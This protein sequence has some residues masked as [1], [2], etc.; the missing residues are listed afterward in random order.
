MRSR[1]RLSIGLLN[2]IA[3]NCKQF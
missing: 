2:P 1:R 3:K